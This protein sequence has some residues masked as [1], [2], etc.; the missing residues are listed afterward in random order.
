MDI[1][2]ACAANTCHFLK[3]AQNDDDMSNLC[4]RYQFA[5]STLHRQDAPPIK[6]V[7]GSRRKPTPQKPKFYLL[8]A[9]P[10]GQYRYISSLYP[11]PSNEPENA[12]QGYS[13]DYKGV[14]LILTLDR[15]RGQASIDPPP[16]PPSLDKAL[17]YQ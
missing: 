2:K 5:N 17:V 9:L 10:S 12:L 8:Q 1:K 4:G 7:I 3:Q 11:N 6:L 15:D 16:N 14:P 13:M